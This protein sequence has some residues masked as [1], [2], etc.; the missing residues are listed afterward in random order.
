VGAIDLFRCPLYSTNTQKALRIME[1]LAAMGRPGSFRSLQILAAE[2]AMSVPTITQLVTFLRRG[3]LVTERRPSGAISLTRPA[4]QISMFDV[5]RATDGAGLL[6]RC[7]LGLAEC[8]DATACPVHSFWKQAREVLEQH[9]ETQT[10]ADLSRAMAQ[11]R[12][13]RRR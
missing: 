8:S 3:G 9:L 12:R 1:R 11:K 13:A 2:T 4:S 7:L 5:I 10:I 6:R